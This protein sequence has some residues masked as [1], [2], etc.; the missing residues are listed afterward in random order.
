MG[1]GF[2]YL[3]VYALISWVIF[4]LGWESLNKFEFKKNWRAIELTH[5]PSEFEGKERTTMSNSFGSR[6]Y[7]LRSAIISSISK[8]W[9]M[10][11]KLDR[12]LTNTC[13]FSKVGTWKH[14]MGMLVKDP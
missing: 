11:N 2:K 9:K 8:R 4:R 14:K 6:D 10:R 3:T 1:G 12:Q 5:D 13:T 7:T